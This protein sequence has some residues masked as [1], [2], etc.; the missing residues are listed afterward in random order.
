MRKRSKLFAAVAFV[1]FIY[2]VIRAIF[3]PVS[4]DEAVTYFLYVQS[5]AFLPHNMIWDANNHILNSALMYPAVKLFGV[6]LLSLRLPNALAFPVYAFFIYSLLSELR[7]RLVF[8]LGATA[9][10]SAPLLLDFFAQARGY[11]LSMA[12]FAGALYFMSRYFSARLPKYQWLAWLCFV[13]TLTANMSM[14][15]SYLIALGLIAAM[16][17]RMF[18][19]SNLKDHLLPYAFGG[20]LPFAGFSV[21]A[22]AMRQRGLLYY[23]NK[24]GF[25]ETTVRLLN[26]YVLYSD[27]LFLARTVA[28]LGVIFG[29]YLLLKWAGRQLR[30]PDSGTVSAVFL[31]GNAAGAVL[32]CHLLEVNY[33]EDRTGLYFVPLFILVA[34][35][36]FDDLVRKVPRLKY[37]ALSLAV[38]PALAVAGGNI[39]YTRLWRDLHM[40][41]ELYDFVAERHP[42][43]HVTVESYFLT[44]SSWSLCALSRDTKL[45]PIIPARNARGLADY[46]ICHDFRCDPYAATHD[47]VY[48]DP[49]NK[50]YLMKRRTPA[51]WHLLKESEALPYF[52]GDAELFDFFAVEDEDI[53][54]RL[55]AVDLT[56]QVK[57]DASPLVCDII[58]AAT[59]EKGEK[60][61]H[62]FAALNWIREEWQGDTLTIRRMVNLPEGS[63]KLVCYVWN[64]RKADVR[65]AFDRITLLEARDKR[66]A[67]SE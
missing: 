31:L 3:V 59:G 9:L 13:L 7:S 60:T 56:L 2:V 20:L 54:K 35:F 41:P 37:A 10:L 42:D 51:A 63:R 6:N 67:G 32:L 27:D 28:L 21:Y 46:A 50:T 19:F 25:V 16:M 44:S 45:A 5:G 23:G 43:G 64:I 1:A 33:P 22:V 14:I 61:F 49:R 8:L 15:N 55:G 40:H 53:L 24:D 11:G 66:P 47:T 36:F 52:N 62:D 34:T 26:K 65:I 58:I 57:A 12:G 4:H 39:G 18:G 29:G 38:F 30:D 17:L 48:K